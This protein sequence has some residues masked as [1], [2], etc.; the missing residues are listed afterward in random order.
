LRGCSRLRI[1]L[2]TSEV[3]PTR[4]ARER[5]AEVEPLSADLRRLHLNVSARF[6]ERVA[7]ACAGLSHAIPGATT[8]QVL[9]AALDLLLEQQAKRRALVKRPRHA[10]ARPAPPADVRAPAAPAPRTVSAAVRR[11]VWTRDEGRCQHP[12][13]AGGICGSTTR[14]ELDHVL[15]VALGGPSAVENL[16]VACWAH[17]REA[18]REVLGPAVMQGAR[19]RGPQRR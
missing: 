12:L 11:E 8:E 14:L 5:R 2:H 15:P 18:A 3:A 4:F 10:R 9:E 1:S 7:A 6:L 16:R 19:R 13:D 17:N